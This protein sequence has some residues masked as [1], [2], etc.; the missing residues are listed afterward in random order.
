MTF[1]KNKYTNEI[2]I[3]EYYLVKRE[4]LD[5]FFELSDLIGN[6]RHLKR[7]QDVTNKIRLI[8]ILVR[9]KI[10]KGRNLENITSKMDNFKMIEDS[11]IKGENL[12]LSPEG[13]LKYFV[14]LQE[15]LDAMGLTQ[16]TYEMDNPSNTLGN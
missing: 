4:I 7:P 5:C 12:V 14:L 3:P 1:D 8:Y 11:V 10:P 13:C 16:I 15:L 9:T 6:M 2:I